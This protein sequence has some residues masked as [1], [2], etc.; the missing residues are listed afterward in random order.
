MAKEA[1][2]MEKGVGY[3]FIICLILLIIALAAKLMGVGQ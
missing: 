3:M 2:K 1:G